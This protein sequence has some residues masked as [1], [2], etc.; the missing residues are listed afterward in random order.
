TDDIAEEYRPFIHDNDG[1]VV[2]ATGNESFS[3]P[4]DMAS[5]PSQLGPNGTRPAAD[6]EKGWIA[7]AALATDSPTQLASYSNA[8]G[9]AMSYCM[10]APGDV[11]VTGKD[12]GPTSPSYFQWKGTSLAAPLV[13]GAAAL[14][15]EAFPYFDNDLVRQT[16][17]GTAQD[18]GEPGTDEV[19]GNGLLD[20]GAAIR[21]PSRLDWG[22]VTVRIDSGSSTWS[23]EL[24]GNGDLIKEGEGTLYLDNDATFDRGIRIRG[25]SLYSAGQINAH[26]GVNPGATFGFGTGIEGTLDNQR[27][28]QVTSENTTSGNVV[29]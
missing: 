20:I 7:V 19:F 24:F 14:V 12:D 26:V 9:I 3:D 27:W 10:V 25:G 1:L 13:S 22:D 16:L 18:L 2:F 29:L 6:L 8:C 15:W 4:T 5:L 11:V 28:V 21:G 23:N 17:L